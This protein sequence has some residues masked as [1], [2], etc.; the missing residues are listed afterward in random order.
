MNYTFRF[1]DLFAG[2]GGFHQAAAKLGGKCVFACEIK[3]VLRETYR[4][5]FGIEP[6]ADIRDVQPSSVPNHDVLFAGFPCQPFSKAGPQSGLEDSIRGTVFWSIVEIL[7]LRR[8]R[9]ILLENVAH[10]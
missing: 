1:A 4:E 5:N 2:L 6:K 8:P 3:Q 7:K 9:M 10:F